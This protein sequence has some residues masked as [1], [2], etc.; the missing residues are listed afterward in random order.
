VVL[1]W[2]TGRGILEL[3]KFA[4]GDDCLRAHFAS[5]GFLFVFDPSWFYV[6]RGRPMS[7]FRVFVFSTQAVWNNKA[8]A[9]VV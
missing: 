6:Q 4:E 9:P 5:E 7:Y 1:T 2:D 3:G 8:K